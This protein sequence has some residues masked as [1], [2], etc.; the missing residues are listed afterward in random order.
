MNLRYGTIIRTLNG[1]VP[2]IEKHVFEPEYALSKNLVEYRTFVLLLRRS[3]VRSRQSR[4]T[5]PI[6]EGFI[7][8]TSAAILPERSES[9]QPGKVTGERTS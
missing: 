9:D 2:G 3:V 4:G 5:K 1:E 7:P 6:M 8:K